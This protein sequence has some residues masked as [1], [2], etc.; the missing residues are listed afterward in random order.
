MPT[1]D[2]WLESC[3]AALP[4]TRVTV[5]GDFCLDAYWLIDRDTSELSVETGLPVHRVRRQRYSL[6]GAGNVAAN[7][8][9][10]G[11]ATVR[12]VGL[13]GDDLFGRQMRERLL[14]QHVDADGLLDT[15]EDWQT[16]VYAKPCLGDDGRVLRRQH[17]THQFA[18]VSGFTP[19]LSVVKFLFA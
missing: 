13:I 16:L 2:N 12:A 18:C 5:F 4:R 17:Q 7:L 11:V 15:Q 6:G 8:A 9:D 1:G 14:Q 19:V 3:L 10:L